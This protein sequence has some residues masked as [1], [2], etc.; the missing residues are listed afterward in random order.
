MTYKPLGYWKLICWGDLRKVFRWVGPNKGATERDGRKEPRVASAYPDS[1]A[2]SILLGISPVRKVYQWDFLVQQ[3]GDS[4]PRGTVSC[5]A[6]LLVA[7]YR[8]IPTLLGPVIPS[9]VLVTAPFRCGGATLSTELSNFKQ[10][11]KK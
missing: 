3:V 2:Y 10:E 5:Q 8:T 6:G 1:T 7:I 4:T 11:L 9:D